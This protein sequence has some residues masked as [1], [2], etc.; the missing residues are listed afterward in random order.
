MLQLP[1]PP[2]ARLPIDASRH[3]AYAFRLFF[4]MIVLPPPPL[5]FFRCC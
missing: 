3:F 4:M 1:L 2:R 5:D